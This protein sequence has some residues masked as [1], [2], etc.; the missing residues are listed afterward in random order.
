M[1][2]FTFT[3]PNRNAAAFLEAVLPLGGGWTLS[4]GLRYEYLRTQVSGSLRSFVFD[5][6]GNV[7]ADTTETWARAQARS[8][9]L[10]GL[11]LSY[12]PG[13]VVEFYANVAQNFRPVL[14]NDM[15]LSNPNLVVDEN[16]RDERGYNA[17]LGMRG[18]WRDGLYFDLTLF[19]LRYNDQIG[20]VLRADQPP[21]FLDYQ[22]RTNVADSRTIG[23]ETLLEVNLLPL[24]GQRPP[25]W[26]LS[27][28]SNATVL[29]G[30]YVHTDDLSILGRARELVPPLIWRTGLQARYLRWE[31][32]VLY[33][34]VH[35]HFTDAT[36][37]PFSATAVVGEVPAY[38]VVDAAL[39]Y[40]RTWL[41][42]EAGIN[43][44]T[45]NR[46]FTRRAAAYP[47]PGIIPA[48][49]RSLYL[50]VE[51]VF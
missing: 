23:L 21:L 43:N 29:D 5:F 47:G 18:H 19:Y 44:L 7:V 4:P 1:K 31:A 45:D 27:W 9:L 49:G 10:A 8:L 36:N 11:G 25:G 17:D 22:Y 6:A 41:T 30:R 15:R 37:A 14:F 34:Y 2:P 48:E 46:Y 13:P 26:K 40:R 42:V 12:R 16:L 38:Y 24:L 20:T 39:R 32:S 50:T 28:F 35:R 51:V 33:A 3:L